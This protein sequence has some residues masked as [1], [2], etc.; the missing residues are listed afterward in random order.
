VLEYWIVCDQMVDTAVD[1]IDLPSQE[2][3][4]SWYPIPKL[5]HQLVDIR[6]IQHHAAQLADRIR[7]SA[8]IGI[9]WVSHRRQPSTIF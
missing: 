4:F 3:G 1:A 9:R 7:A 8:D 6:H 5:E 2:S